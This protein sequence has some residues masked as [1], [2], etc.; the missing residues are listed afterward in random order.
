MLSFNSWVR[1][2]KSRY[3]TV[4][5]VGGLGNQLFGY[6]AGKYLAEKLDCELRFDISQH[7][8]GFTAHGSSIRSFELPESFESVQPPF[9]LAYRLT[10]R[11]L[12]I[13]GLDPIRF[14]VKL[15]KVFKNY[16][17]NV[18]GYDPNLERITAP[19][20]VR[21]YFQTFVYARRVLEALGS[22]S[23]RLT[24]PSGWYLDRENALL[25]KRTLA[26][27]VR[28]GDYAKLSDEFG[29][30]APAY[31]LEGI[32][33]LEGTFG[34]FDEIWVYSDEVERVEAEFSAGFRDLGVLAKTVWV[35]PP[36]GTDAAESLSLMSK[37]SANIISNSTFSWWAAT[38]NS[39]QQIVAPS[40]WFK[41]KAD[42][43]GLIP[44]E[45]LSIASRWVS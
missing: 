34:S 35:T 44:P 29:M 37:A 13:I 21:G 17:A 9:N 43:Q 32:A 28:R 14:E 38:L 7:D 24:N 2:K 11:A 42:P 12:G 10:R 16:T 40:K 22:T 36:N 15:G 4:Q 1:A 6:F 19:I 18:D 25:G 39:S 3:V 41:G 31:Y 5:L 26:V 33:T 45:W 23:L 20:F 27:H 30:L 8:K